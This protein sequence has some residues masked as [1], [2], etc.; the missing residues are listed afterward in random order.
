MTGRR[1]FVLL[2]ALVLGLLA[3][4]SLVRAAEAKPTAG[5]KEIVVEPAGS[6]APADAAGD[7]APADQAPAGDQPPAAGPAPDDAAAAPADAAP[8][9]DDAAPPAEAAGPAPAATPAEEVS[10]PVQP[11]AVDIAEPADPVAKAA[12]DVLEKNCS[13]CHQD[14]K[15]VKRLKPAK[16]FGFILKLQELAADP[17]YIVPGNP[18]GSKI[19][20]MILNK[21]M[22]YDVY[23][24][25]DLT[26]N[27]PSDQDVLALRNWIT[28][29]GASQVAACTDRPFI[30]PVDMVKEMADDLETLDKTRVAD[31]RYITLTHLYNACA[32]D[33][34]M[35]VYRQATVKLLNSLSSVSDVVK[36]ETIDKAKTIVRFNLKDVGWTPDDW[37]KVLAV[38][39]YAARPD[40]QAFDLLSSST[41]TPLAYVQG[42]WFAFTA[43]QGTLYNQLTDIAENFDGLQKN[44]GVDIK[45]D[46][47]GFIVKRAGFQQSGVSRNNRLIERHTIATGY[48]WTSYD[49]AG[50]RAKQS[51]FEFPVGPGDGQFDFQHNGGETIY[52]LPNGFQGYFLSKSTG[53]RLDKGPTNIVLD[54]SQ[55]DQTVTNGVSCMGCH[56]QGIRKAKDEVRAHVTA[57]RT[58]PKSVRDA[59]DAL[60][61]TND[62]MDQVLAADALKFHNAMVE[63]GLDPTLK[64][65]GVEMINALAKRYENDIELKLAAAEFGQ[66][67]KQFVDSLGGAADPE[68]TRLGR[69]LQQGL[70]PRDGF[71]TEFKDLVERVS[72]LQSLDMK[73]LLGGGAGAAPPPEV[74]KPTRPITD[75][76]D[77]DLSLISDNSSYKVNDH[78][79]FTVTPEADC[80]LTL[81]NIDG[82]GLA[83][84]LYPNK[85]EKDNRLTAGKDFKFPAADAP[86]QFRF[87]DPGVVE[88]VV[89][90]CSLQDRPVDNVKIDQTREFTDLGNY[91]KHLTRSIQ[92]EAKTPI[93]AGGKKATPDDIVARAAIKMKVQ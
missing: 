20:Q 23:Y 24:E 3:T 93:V 67:E 62:E 9:A 64:L 54:P 17:H 42:D 90:T 2:G 80:F 50:N 49:F 33:A 70:V 44:I 51:L 78:P 4:T 13:R 71:E 7:Q 79:T 53:E 74:A 45:K 43:S 26:K 76:R 77:F 35:E 31:T 92:V 59:V 57:D 81:I 11:A 46:L 73:K 39:P 60:Y 69:R 65:N 88:T 86:Y 1:N 22:P 82:K 29:L 6:P 85:L 84:V 61:P 40:T 14:G 47:D 63:A 16:N 41:L 66:D 12:F 28:E 32:G 89:A 27:P 52:S 72:D 18:D 8:P 55:R 58:F 56:D 48:L 19:M 21:E 68:A 30:T 37:N 91:Q 15:L 10:E 75:K 38:Y 36:L 34:A 25:A 5:A 87:T 83:T